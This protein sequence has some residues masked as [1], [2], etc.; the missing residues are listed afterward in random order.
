MDGANRILNPHLRSKV[1]SAAEA[2]LA[3]HEGACTTLVWRA[4]LQ[5]GADLEVV[6]TEVEL[7]ILGGRYLLPSSL[8]RSSRLR[9]LTPAAWETRYPEDSTGL[10]AG[11]PPSGLTTLWLSDGL[12]HPGR[13]A[14]LAA[15]AARGEVTVVK[16]VERH[17]QLG[18]LA[19]GGIA[20]RAM[21]LGEHGDG[22]GDSP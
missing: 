4:W 2:A 7:P 15:L 20:L 14:L 13:A 21:R 6:F 9:A 17:T 12:D 10:L 22:H 11:A 8:S 16:S 18:E 5:S 1:M 19:L 3:H